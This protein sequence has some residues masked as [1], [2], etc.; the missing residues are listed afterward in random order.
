M[1]PKEY[2]ILVL[3]SGE[4]G[5]YVAWNLSKQG[6]KT[7]LV[8]RKYIGGSCPNIAC[9]PSK[10]IIHS[11]KVA[12]LFF[13][14]SEFGIS[15]DHVQI[16][17]QGVFNR[18]KKM[19]DDLVN[20]HID[21]FHKTGVELIIGEGKFIAPK[22]L[23]VTN[24][25][26]K[27]QTLSGKK[28]IISTGSTSAIPSIPGIQEVK[29]LTHIEILDLQTLPKTLIILGGGYIALEFAQAMR[30]FGSEVIIIERN[31]RLAHREDEDVSQAIEQLFLDEGVSIITNAQVESIEGESGKS[32]VVH[33]TTNGYKQTIQG[34]HLLVATGRIPNTANIGLELAG[35][36]LTANKHVKVNEMLQT[37][38][39]D[40]WAAGDCAGS[41][42]F[43]HI[44]YDDSRV[45][46]DNINGGSKVTTGRQIPYCMFID[47]E[48][49]RIGL[50]ENEAKKQKI[51]YLLA[52]IPMSAVLR[53]RTLSE[54]R[55]F[56]KALVDPKSKAILG[57]AALGVDAGEILGSIQVAVLAK[58]S[59]QALKD[60]PFTHPTLIEG[61][62]PL[63]STIQE[64]Q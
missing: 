57:F 41:P 53:T 37:T 52:K 40:I 20:M 55:G 64:P 29:P 18:K 26:G 44:A 54:T 9:L 39:S 24:K 17:M 48:F 13:R 49:A 34:S 47:P 19:I 7:A 27:T 32:V 5:K 14:R 31:D 8:E 25:D 60:A 35:V 16:D 36:E 10:N 46:L 62:G 61:L 33:L 6:F 2:D 45:I 43:T 23:Q 30:R 21:I 1:E 22:T 38:A 11:S 56:M 12:S 63:F 15:A 51:D 3:G 58:L 50:S 42:H 28:I 59:Y 4:G